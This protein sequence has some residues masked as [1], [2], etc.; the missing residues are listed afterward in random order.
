[1]ASVDVIIPNYQYGRY[2]RECLASVLNQGIEDVRVLIIDNASTD[3][4][5]VIANELAAQDGR[6]RVRAHPVN[7]GFHSSVNEGLDWVESEYVMV[8]CADDLLPSGALSRAIAIME[9]NPR[10]AFAYGNYATVTGSVD[11]LADEESDAAWKVQPGMDFIR[12]CCGR[13]VNV[14]APLVRTRI[15][16][17]AGYYRP[18]LQYTSDL[19]ILLRFACL[20][21]VAVTSNVQAI[22]R[23]HE[24][25]ISAVSWQNPSVWLGCELSIVDSFFEHEGLDLPEG[26]RLHRAARRNIAKRAYWRGIAFILRGQ[27]VAGLDLLRSAIRLAPHLAIFPP[28]SEIS[29]IDKPLARIIPLIHRRSA[30]A[31]ECHVALK[32]VRSHRLFTLNRP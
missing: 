2:L 4:S 18:A 32:R 28:L 10:A 16:K 1:M 30:T 26:R 21:D 20:G 27:S 25:N 5:L 24:M 19:E 31:I 7:L 17:A 12:R 22:Q 29:K 13:M 23:I 11:A 8:L 3:D 6:V 15:Q 14:V 9:A